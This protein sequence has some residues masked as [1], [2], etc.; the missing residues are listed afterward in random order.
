MTTLAGMQGGAAAAGLTGVQKA[1]VLMMLFGQSAATQV[2]KALPPDE[3]K[4]LGAA[5]YT[6]RDVGHDT[7]NAVLNEFL[8]RLRQQT[9]IAQDASGYVQSV[10]TDALGPDRAQSVL[11][12]ITPSGNTRAIEIL[13]WVDPAAIAELI[14][15]EHPQIVALIVA[16]LDPG[17]AAEVLGLLDVAM[18]PDIVHRIATLTTVQPEAL[19]EL[20]KVMQRKFSANASLRASQVGGVKAAAKIMNFTKQDMELRIMKEI[21]KQD[22]DLTES[23][24]DSMFTFENLIKSDD[25]SL[26]T[27]LRQIEPDTLVLALKGAE[28]KLRDRLL[29]CM[30]SR[31]AAGILDDLEALGPMRLTLVQEAQKE[32]VNVARGMADAGTIMLAGRGGETMV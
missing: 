12:R 3:V 26:Q 10:L 11:S 13:D 2:L 7:V 30:S 1:A 17:R 20:E 22:R 19:N 27:L 4:A 31:A 8:G 5:M 16:S 15:D 9:E 6:V 32:I 28:D 18:Q 24:Q 23:L 21:R 14:S 29:S 25:R